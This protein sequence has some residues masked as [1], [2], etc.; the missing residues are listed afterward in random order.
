MTKYPLLLQTLLQSTPPDDPEQKILDQAFSLVR[1]VVLKIND[2]LGKQKRIEIWQE[3]LQKEVDVFLV[4]F[5]F[6]L[7]LLNSLQ[8]TEVTLDLKD[9]L[10]E[11]CLKSAAQGVEHHFIISMDKQKETHL[12][13]TK[14][15][16]FF[17]QPQLKE[18]FKLKFVVPL[19]ML[20]VQVDD[21][22]PGSTLFLW[23]LFLAE[24]FV[25]FLFQ[26]QPHSKS[27]TLGNEK[28][29][30]SWPQMLLKRLSGSLS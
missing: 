19:N 10:L 28:S 3:L 30:S 18:S 21:Q 13:L 4:S 23:G 12:V 6:W 25:L 26:M 17:F 2:I 11:G 22:S 15:N 29:T 14:D 7:T 9:I 8:G 24:F 5:L 27:S 1:D 20:V 16:L